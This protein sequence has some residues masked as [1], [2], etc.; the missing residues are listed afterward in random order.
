MIA[1]IV[2]SYICHSV[3]NET[4]HCKESFVKIRIPLLSVF[5]EATHASECPAWSADTYSKEAGAGGHDAHD[6][7]NDKGRGG[8]W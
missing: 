7:D 8:G 2:K 1:G 5:S 3:T 4:N 6:A